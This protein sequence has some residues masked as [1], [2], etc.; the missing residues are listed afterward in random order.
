MANGFDL[1][2]E[3]TRTGGTPA[4]HS[5]MLSEFAYQ[6]GWRPGNSIDGSSDTRHLGVA[7]LIVEH[8]LEN[9]AVL[10]FLPED[11]KSSDLQVDERRRLLEISYNNLVDWHIWIDRDTVRYVYNRTEPATDVLHAPISRTEYSALSQVQFEQA[12]GRAP[13]P[14]LPA[15]DDAL[16]DTIS[17]W[18]KLL[19]AQ[20]GEEVSNKNLS[21]LFN[22]ILLTRAVEDVLRPG[23][24]GDEPALLQRNLRAGDVAGIL[25]STIRKM[26]N[27]R[28]PAVLWDPEDLSPFNALEPGDLRALF[29]D[30]Y[31]H[32]GLPY[33]FDF[34]V[35]SK[36]ALSRIY[37][38]YVSLLRFS[39]PTEQGS[40]IPP[41]PT[42]ET[43]KSLGT[44]YTPEFIA[45]FF[46]RFLQEHLPPAIFKRAKIADLACGS[47][48]FLRSVLEAQLQSMGNIR[49]PTLVGEATAGLLGIDIDEN[50]CMA[51]RLSLA[52]LHLVATGQLP[53][54]LS[55][56][57]DS[58]LEFFAANPDLQNSLD[59]FV[60]NPP[61]IRT[62]AQTPETRGA[63]ADFLAGITTG[64]LDTYMAFLKMGV[65]AL[66]PGRFGLF[67][68]PQT[69]LVS[70]GA[71]GIRDWV[72]ERAWVRCLADLAAVPVF[73][74]VG[75]YVI[76]L[77]IEKKL[78]TTTSA[79][80][81]VMIRARSYPGFALQDYLDG[82]SVD[83]P[84]YK[85]FECSQGE[86]EKDTWTPAT[87]KERA[88][89]NRLLAL[90]R[91]N[92][93]V[94]VGQ[95][96]ITG[97]DDVFIL[98]KKDV[99]PGEE[100]L[101]RPFIPDRKIPQFALPS[102]TGA[103]MWYPFEGDRKFTEA[104]LRKRFPKSW[105]RLLAHRARLEARSPVRR[106][107]IQWWEIAWPRLPSKILAPKIIGP[108]VMLVPRFALDASGKW[109]VT[110]GSYITSKQAGASTD[111]LK[112]VLAVLNSSVAAWFF[113]RTA[114]KYGGGYN[115]IEVGN[116]KGLPIPDPMA[117]PSELLRRLLDQ[118]DLIAAAR[119]PRLSE[120]IALDDLVTEA[121]EL[122]ESERKALSG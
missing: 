69:F 101:Y 27:R 91:L 119:P 122:G 65:E 43:N 66:K 22:A 13:N 32:R 54:R 104:E 100:R 19:G 47:G 33:R 107:D 46:A 23:T 68:L 117:I 90:P 29:S 93:L 8:G 36:H 116:L 96:V 39:E 84:N 44:V 6:L 118:V 108:H 81:A 103:R 80:Q 99:P 67:V 88:I 42:E 105:N 70:D 9:S 102:E 115:R 94:D 18:K 64:R 48:I 83:G 34:A 71:K 110:R 52:V 109:L 1:V 3:L 120:R 106:G 76:L 41:L 51:T 14:N 40:F 24:S 62:E 25:Q 21:A 98:P 95:G 60:V 114:R 55:V 56:K 30:F 75:S 73:G 53:D 87:P 49:E 35:M 61:F 45:R 37:E 26:T 50:A 59:G 17:R 12:I 5:Q 10:T 82:K 77:V 7:H 38:R 112:Y 58:A 63:L 72:S 113:A 86:F 89:E 121:Y 78:T 15:L 11:R 74:D 2:H 79:P 28:I 92:E 97:A 111:V 85:T 31:R 4:A 20:L 16:I 57:T